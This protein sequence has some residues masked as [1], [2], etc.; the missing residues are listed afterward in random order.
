MATRVAFIGTGGI[1]GAHLG[2]LKDEADVAIVALCDLN[3]EGVE[4]KATDYGATAYTDYTAMLDTEQPD[5]VWLCTPPIVRR[6][7]LL[8]CARRGIP[9]FCEKPA[10]RE[11][12]AALALA[13]ELAA[14]DA[15]VQVGYVFRPTPLVQ[16]LR[17]LIADDR[18]HSLQS[19]YLCPMSLSLSLSRRKPQEPQF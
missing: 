8:A 16:R 17:E 5:A 14:L 13:A 4:A 11:P 15:K 10:E 6:E 9:V 12:A 19:T 3:R 18:I 2:V 1:S 7:P